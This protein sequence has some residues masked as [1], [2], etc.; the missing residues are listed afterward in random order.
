M[1]LAAGCIPVVGYNIG[2]GRKDRARGLFTLLL[3]WE[4]AV[5]FVALL[6][7]ELF[8]R[9]L[10]G[11]FGAGN[12]SEYYTAFAIR[13]FR[14]YLC[15]LP[16]ATINKGTFIYLQALGKAVPSMVLSMVREIIF[17]VFLPILLPRIFG[18]NGVL[19]SFPVADVL[20]FILTVIIVVRIYREL[21]TGNDA[22][23]NE[24][25]SEAVKIL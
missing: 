15:M 24:T 1:G 6:I 16:L 3:K 4:A 14:V 17:G 9:Q 21:S 18:L 10:I 12:E 8:P 13:C 20:T 19:Y 11:I 22:H 5:G 7:V 23:A 25:T 2:A